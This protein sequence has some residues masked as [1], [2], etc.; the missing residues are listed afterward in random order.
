MEDATRVLDRLLEIHVLLQ[1]DLARA[2]EGNGLTTARTHL[3]WE[4]RRLGPTTQQALAAALEVSPRNVTGLV[5]G[6]ESSGF[7]VRAPHPTDRRATLVSLTEL[8]ELTM[9]EMATQHVELSQ[10][11]VGDMSQ[12]DV[13]KL[14]KGLDTVAGRLRTLVEA[15]EAGITTAA[16]G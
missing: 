2:L 6:L 12:A 4:L 8:G 14:A 16:T 13:R 1:R 15:E 5:D 11:L 3:L 9:G 7:V 10:Q